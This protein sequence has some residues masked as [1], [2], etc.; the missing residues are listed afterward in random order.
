VQCD[1]IAD[2]LTSQMRS[3]V[4]LMGPMI[5]RCGQINISYPGGCEI[6]LRPIDIHLK[7]LRQL[8]VEIKENHGFL[9]CDG[10][11][12]RG[13]VVQL[14]FPSVG[15]TEN[16]MMAAVL[17]EGETRLQ[18]VAREPEV[19]DLQNFLN[20]MGARIKG[21]GTEEIIVSGVKTLSDTQYNVMPDRIA[22]GT[23]LTAAA[24]T[25]GEITA[26]DM[27]P[28]H[29]GIVLS[30]LRE[31]GCKVHKEEALVHIRAP[32]RLSEIRIKT[33]PYP[34]FPTDMQS[35]FLAALCTARGTS[36]I[37]ETIFESR[38]KP[39]EELL[40][41]GA[42]II[43]E[44]RL[45]IITGV[46]RLMGAKL[47]AG[48][49]RGGAALVLAGLAAEGETVIENIEYIDRGYEKLE[50]SLT[51]LGAKISRVSEDGKNSEE[52]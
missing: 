1:G 45:A 48:D 40:K 41:M 23:F 10:S 13:N 16:G 26:R 18:N 8:G 15:A 44:D 51:C 12:L 20:S 14:D 30:K 2:A 34:G 49:L 4:F 43:V 47:S 31:A 7:V 37:K 29:L 46:K 19:V 38:Y 25:G 39:V 3:S 50:N 22:A 32:R 24:I 17:A 5:A 52:Q 33:L 21:A 35:Q 42:R 11:K 6:G 27:E 9:Q 36:I 28:A